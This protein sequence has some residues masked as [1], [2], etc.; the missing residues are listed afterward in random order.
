MP[1]NNKT[2]PPF[3]SVIT[4]TY[5]TKELTCVCL[6]KL[7]ASIGKLA[8]PVEVIVVENG[9]DGTG[10][11]LKKDYP[12]I[13]VIT[14]G[15]N[16]GYARGNNLGL[17]VARKDSS[18]LL[19]LNTDAL[20][21]PDTLIMSFKFLSDHPDCDVLGCRLEFKDGRMQPSAGFLPNPAN[22]VSWMFGLDK[23][24]LLK[25]LAAPI[26]PPSGA[27]FRSDHRVG[28]VM[29]AF[30][31]MKRRVYE[32]TGGLDE[33]Y[34][35]YGEEVEWCQ[36]IKDGGFITWYTPGFSVTHLDKASSGGDIRKGIVREIQGL[37]HFMNKYYPGNMFWLKWVIKTGM[38][39]RAL[40]FYILGNK[41]RAAVHWEAAG[42]I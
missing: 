31:L 12:W 34:F 23:L 2:S 10:E 8:K 19:L 22:T 14:P 33:N 15:E 17:K 16:T 3:L 6:D 4:C 1:L 32:V 24:P 13:K 36:R 41:Y 11:I 21:R 27:F 5:N 37:D 42:I 25:N 18:W 26:H 28:W 38:L 39:A 30:M 29:G 20:I 9:T 35:M 40:A 7:Q